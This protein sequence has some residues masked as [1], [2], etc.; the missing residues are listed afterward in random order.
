MIPLSPVVPNINVITAPDTASSFTT[1]DTVINT[2]RKLPP[3]PS[4]GPPNTSYAI[5]QQ[6]GEAWKHSS[7]AERPISFE[8]AI[9]GDSHSSDSTTDRSLD[10]SMPYYEVPS[11][12]LA[13]VHGRNSTTHRITPS[14]FD[15]PLEGNT[16]DNAP[17]IS[18]HVTFRPPPPVPTSINVPLSSS[19]SRP[20]SLINR[21]GKDHSRLI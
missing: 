10:R 8:L 7:R 20:Y 5:Q 19:D 18:T 12:N 21:S 17:K 2:T 16:L 1:E 6:P 3:T 15:P 13:Y 14:G 11:S 9:T 4:A